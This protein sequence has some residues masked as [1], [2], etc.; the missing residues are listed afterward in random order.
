MNLSATPASCNPPALMQH[1]VLRIARAPHR[2]IGHGATLAFACMLLVSASALQAAEPVAGKVSAPGATAGELWSLKPIRSARLPEVK[3]AA[4]PATPIDV[5][6]LASLEARGLSPSP[7]AD[8]RTLIRRATIDLIGLPATEEEIESFLA[9]ESPDA[10]ARVVDRLLASPHYGERWGRHWLDVARFA[11]TKDG[12]LMYGDDRV[13]PH[14]YT[15]RDYVI[16]ALN[17][18][19]P[20]DRFVHE[21]L[22]AD[23]IE[24]KVESWRLAAMGF[25]T[26]GRMFDN[27]IHD[28]IDDRIDTVTRGL[29]GL[30][31]SCARCHDHKYDAIP[32]ADYYSLY[33][34]FASS[35][36]PLELPLVAPP[37]H[38][39]EAEEFE[40][41][42][43]AKRAE[44][45]EFLDRQ[46]ALQT[47][48]ARERVADYLVRVA[49]TPPD[50]LETAI[51]FLSLAPEDLRPPIVARWR[52][53][54][55]SRSQLADPVF[56]LWGELLALSEAEFAAGSPAV[57]DRWKARVPGVESGQANPLVVEA[58]AAAAPADRAGVARAYGD[59]LARVYKE[60]K[61]AREPGDDAPRAQLLE[62]L[63]GHSSPITFPKSQTRKYMS[64]SETD[65]FG[66]KLQE[67][68]RMAVRSP[69]A[70]PR[71]M[72]LV[73]L[74][75]PYEPRIFERGN[76]ANPGKPV[77]RQFLAI[78]AGDSR[79][80]FSQGS[81]RLELARA[82]T[83]PNNSLTSRVIVNRIWMHHL[84]EP[85]VATPG[86]FGLRSNPPTHPELLD[87]LAS[88]LQADGW[89]LKRLHRRI[90]LS[91][92]YQQSSADRPDGRA[93]DAENRL[94]WRANRRRIDFEVM[95][96]SLLAVS[97]RLDRHV[98]GR[99]V[100]A[101]GDPENRRRTVYA[102]V[103]R[104]SLPGL[105][106]AFDFAVP[107][108]SVERRPMTTVP[109]QALFGLNSP[110]VHAQARALSARGAA[111]GAVAREADVAMRIAALYRY[112]YARSPSDE[113]LQ[114]AV[115]FLAGVESLPAGAQ[116][117]A[118][119]LSSWE[120]LAQVLLLSNELMFVD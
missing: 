7:A 8:R 111:R 33:G 3:N 24:P 29:M 80:P 85:L 16:R 77:P 107:D 92:V 105:F 71:A 62:V 83:A 57:I 50:P 75:V 108:Q 109:Q 87:E 12:V 98:G 69:H 76:P 54:V 15:Y 59:L 20:F 120:Q 13:R 96:D 43:A 118:A 19:L 52:R 53:M 49:T 51:F 100:D 5:W 106:R 67:L 42:V 117:D 55:S 78:V 72:A 88:Q 81:G 58:L 79:Q 115:A 31:V 84:G 56:G 30:T 40:K 93:L 37:P 2:P 94:Y 14:A 9:D 68:D 46:F 1:S 95:R 38:S 32:M 10:F 17:E 74:P 23:L 63:T 86:D 34:V 22:A 35:E 60:S 4:W 25:L 116:P 110:F 99:P 64:R 41:Q 112:V 36:L 28:V 114:L 21:Q 104:Q 47:E 97:G 70:P 26:L 6:I 18:D 61:E 82:I 90:M 65:A 101:A 102:L 119:G 103:D 44:A 39:P 27:N 11:D 45:Q 66:G 113:E 48:T 91:N 73:D 89:S